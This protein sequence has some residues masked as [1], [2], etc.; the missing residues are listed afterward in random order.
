MSAESRSEYEGEDADEDEEWVDEI[1][2]EC[3]IRISNLENRERRES[4]CPILDPLRLS[5]YVNCPSR[6]DGDSL[7]SLGAALQP[8]SVIPAAL[9]RP[10]AECSPPPPPLP[11]RPIPPGFIANELPPCSDLSGDAHCPADHRQVR[12]RTCMA[13]GRPC[14]VQVAPIA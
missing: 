11:A 9:L 3:E 12:A 5:Q 14:L 8:S 4:L 7:S 6:R 2:D 1:E 13:V 10:S